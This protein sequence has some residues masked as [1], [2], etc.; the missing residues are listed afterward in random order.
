MCPKHSLPL[1]S[2]LY[3]FLFC[4]WVY[5]VKDSCLFIL[6]HPSVRPIQL[7]SFIFLSFVLTLTY[8]PS[9][10]SP[11]P[12]PLL[13]LLFTFLVLSIPVNAQCSIRSHL[14]IILSI[15]TSSDTCSCS[16]AIPPHLTSRIFAF[17]RFQFSPSLFLSSTTI[18]AWTFSFTFNC[19]FCGFLRG[20][21]CEW[22]FAFLQVTVRKSFF[23]LSLTIHTVHPFIRS[24]AHVMPCH[25][26]LI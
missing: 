19:L 7:T 15:S 17:V 10:Y 22:E 26:R 24:Y 2:S 8:S 18:Q 1:L 23:F 11:N 21:V 5:G 20:F 9:H 25:A 6:H 13:P 14:S 12:S 4:F 16:L 3:S